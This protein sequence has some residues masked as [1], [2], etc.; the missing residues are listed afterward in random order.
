M[1]VHL[2]G[3]YQNDEN[4]SQDNTTGHKLLM[5]NDICDMALHKHKDDIK[6]TTSVRLFVVWSVCFKSPLICFVHKSRMQN[7]MK[8]VTKKEE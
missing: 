7:F 1:T 2:K 8:Y 3:L 5:A 6:Q 4:R